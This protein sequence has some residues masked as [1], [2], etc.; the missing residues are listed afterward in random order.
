[1]RG[2]T[3]L[4]AGVAALAAVTACNGDRA[5][6]S[7]GGTRVLLTD[8]PFPFDQVRSVD[9]YI[10]RVD[11]ATTFDTTTAV[12]WTTLVAPERRFNLLDVQGGKT[13]LL[14]ESQVPAGRY[15]AI[16]MVIRTDLSGIVLSDGSA[17]TVDWLGPATQTIHAG[18]EQPLDLRADG[19]SGD[20][21]IDFDVGRSFV[22]VTDG[23]FHFLPWI[24][25]VSSNATGTIRGTVTGS[26]GPTAAVAP[27][28][29]ASISL[30]R[31]GFGARTL[32]ATGKSDA[33]G[34]YAIHYVSGGG[35]YLVE[36]AP[37]AGFQAG[38]GYTHD[39][40]VT[41]GQEIVVDVVLGEGTSGGQERRL[42]ISGPSQVAVGHAITLAAFVFD[43]HGDSLYGAP[44]TWAHGNAAVA[45]LD[46]SG[47]SVQLTG[48]AGG[49][50][51][52]VATSNELVDSVI[53][54]VGE[55]GAPVA[56]VWSVDSSVV[57]VLSAKVIVH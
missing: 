32:A 3:I 7:G 47:A 42:A 2:T 37:P 1:M 34:R 39:V 16:R 21:V 33:Q 35:P 15:A 25:A 28:A 4:A 51:A 24:R 12:D 55:E 57:R 56:S 43:E 38:Y 9:V 14:G 20:L 54:T 31:E 36:A 10:V 27:V 17:A 40:D 19:T 45:R 22:P 52:V 48:L 49:A 53:V 41:P 30:Y 13:A 46:G 18:V 26:D 5:A 8:A 6:G 11:A 29:N 44:V 23:G 50:T